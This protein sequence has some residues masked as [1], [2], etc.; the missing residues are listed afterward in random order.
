MSIIHQFTKK[1]QEFYCYNYYYRRTDNVLIV[2]TFLFFFGGGGG[3][4]GGVKLEGLVKCLDIIAYLSCKAGF[5][6]QLTLQ[7]EHLAGHL[8]AIACYIDSNM[9][10]LLWETNSC[11]AAI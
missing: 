2:K 5:Y 7:V 6:K 11:V 3:G 4:G 1:K 8:G 9:H 10:Q